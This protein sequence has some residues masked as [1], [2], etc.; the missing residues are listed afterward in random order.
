MLAAEFVIYLFGVPWLAY[1]VGAAD[2][3]PKGMFPF[4]PGDII[5]LVIAALVLPSTWNLVGRQRKSG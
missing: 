3:L 2:A 4:I 1:F 5:K